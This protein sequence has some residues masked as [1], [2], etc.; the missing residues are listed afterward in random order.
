MG[1]FR[2]DGVWGDAAW[3]AYPA[4]KKKLEENGIRF[5]IVDYFPLLL[6]CIHKKRI[7]SARLAGI[8]EVIY[9]Y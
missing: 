9:D 3:E 5:F 7:K 2:S 8:Q 4:L 1:L 6:V